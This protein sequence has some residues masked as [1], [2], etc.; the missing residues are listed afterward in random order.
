MLKLAVLWMCEDYSYNCNN[1]SI[2]ETLFLWYKLVSP[3]LRKY[4]APYCPVEDTE[5]HDSDS[6][7]AVSLNGQTQ[8]DGTDSEW[9]E[10][11]V[12]IVR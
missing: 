4:D 11:G 2:F 12:Q 9:R 10:N 1:R 7:E 6:D 8:A 3:E 5:S